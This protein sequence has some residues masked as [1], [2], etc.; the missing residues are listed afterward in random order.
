MDVIV[1]QIGALALSAIVNEGAQPSLLGELA[2][3]LKD[4]IPTSLLFLVLVIAYDLLLNRPLTATLARR[5]ALT[6]GAMEEAQKAVARAEAKTAEYTEKLRLARSEAYKV[7]EQR[8]TQ[9]SAER[10]TALEQ[11]RKNA[12]ERVSLARAELDA[13]TAAACK[14]IEASAADL[15]ARA[16]RAVLPVAAGGVR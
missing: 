12:H 11:V 2:G 9:W 3:L 4:A 13:E 7:R 15:A 8:V 1:Q 6:E 14:A 16:V 5:K 10:D